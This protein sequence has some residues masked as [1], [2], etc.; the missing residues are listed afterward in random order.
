M[1]I[2]FVRSP[3]DDRLLRWCRRIGIEMTASVR[4]S[5]ADRGARARLKRCSAPGDALLEPAFH[6]FIAVI[7]PSLDDR[8]T[9]IHDQRRIAGLARVAILIPHV[10]KVDMSRR[11]ATQL[12]Q[13]VKPLRLRA[14]IRESDPDEALGRWRRLLPLLGAGVHVNEL[15]DLVMHWTESKRRTLAFNYFSA[16]GL[17]KS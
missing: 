17:T 3:H 10:R 9:A 11:L 13:N 15:A 14:V 12:A 1:S 6:D 2:S 16:L 4:D 5:Y 7:V 8:A